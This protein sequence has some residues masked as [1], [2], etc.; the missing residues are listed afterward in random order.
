[1]HQL[2]KN[3]KFVEMQQKGITKNFMLQVNHHSVKVVVFFNQN[4]LIHK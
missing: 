4:R 1:M 2:S 3:A